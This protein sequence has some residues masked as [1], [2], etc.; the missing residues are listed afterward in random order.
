MS[1]RITH[2]VDNWDDWIVGEDD[3]CTVPPIVIEAE[4]GLQR[5]KKAAQEQEPGQTT[6]DEAPVNETSPEDDDDA[7]PI[8][9]SFSSNA[10]KLRMSVSTVAREAQKEEDTQKKHDPPSKSQGNRNK[11]NAKASPLD[12]ASSNRKPDPKLST[13]NSLSS[14]ATLNATETS[15]RRRLREE[16]SEAG[17]S[18][19]SRPGTSAPPPVALSPSR[20]FL[21]KLKDL[22]HIPQV[23]L[24]QQVWRRSVWELLRGGCKQ[25]RVWTFGNSLAS[26]SLF[27]NDP[28]TKPNNNPSSTPLDKSEPDLFSSHTSQRP[29]PLIEGDCTPLPTSSLWLEPLL[30]LIPLI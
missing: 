18:T 30:D 22:P 8:R 7:P 23:P 16:K 12:R 20:Q 4:G 13:A 3:D 9:P 14:T 11:P 28:P 27:T 26:S 29:L 1:A 24:S 21:N 10:R 25:Q 6:A 17:A 2:D 5:Q 15:S 19:L